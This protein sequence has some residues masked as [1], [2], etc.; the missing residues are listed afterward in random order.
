MWTTGFLFLLLPYGTQ[1][2]LT[3]VPSNQVA[4]IGGQVTFLCTVNSTGAARWTWYPVVGPTCEVFTGFVLGICVNQTRYNVTPRINGQYNLIINNTVMSDAGTFVCKDVGDTNTPSAS[5][6]YGVISSGPEVTSSTSQSCLFEGD[7]VVLTCRAKYNGS[8][9][10]PLSMTWTTSSGQLVNSN[11]TNDTTTGLLQS[12]FY[13]TANT[14]D[15]PVHHCNVTFSPPT[16]DTPDVPLPGLVQATNAP[17]YSRVA[18]SSAYTVLYCPRT[19]TVKQLNGDEFAGGPGNKETVVYCSVEGG[20]SNV[21]TTYKWT[22][23][24][25]GDFLSNNQSIKVPV[26]NYK[27]TCTANNTVSCGAGNYK[28]CDDDISATV[29]LSDTGRGSYK[30]S[31]IA[32]AVMLS[33]LCQQLS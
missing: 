22:D 30:T 32:M 21:T 24:A 7:Q 9:V 8:N 4:V 18:M 23:T 14:S 3:V 20:S 26:S 28:T 5:A 16:S 17:T 6:V 31:T 1:S 29:I 2:A 11:M 12:T 15:I 27:F 33:L 25:T 13:I 10:M 19:I